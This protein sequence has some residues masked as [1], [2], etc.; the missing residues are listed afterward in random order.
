V[1]GQCGCGARATWAKDLNA[2]A[3]ALDIKHTL[4]TIPRET[5]LR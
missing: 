2:I 5:V 3:I 4:G 1:Q